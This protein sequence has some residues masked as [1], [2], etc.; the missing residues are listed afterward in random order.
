MSDKEW[1]N[2]IKEVKDN[3]KK[4]GHVICPAFGVEKVYF[5]R[6]GF[7]HLLYRKGDRRNK[8]DQINRLLLIDGAVEIVSNIK[9]YSEYRKDKDMNFWSL[10]GY[11]N[12]KKITVIIAQLDGGIK[13]FLSVMVKSTKTS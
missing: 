2:Y 13:Y 8:K 5:N 6:K 1:R 7:Q 3:Y 10:V 4:I 11:K 12:N 9:S